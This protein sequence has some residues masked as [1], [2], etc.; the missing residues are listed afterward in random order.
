[1][2]KFLFY[3][4]G[5]RCVFKAGKKVHRESE[6]K[7]KKIKSYKGFVFRLRLTEEQESLCRQ[8]IGTCRFVWNKALE[9]KKN[10]WEH[11]KQN[12]SRAELDKR[13]TK[14]KRQ[15]TWMSL[16]PS[17]SLQQVIKDLDQAFKSF[18]NGF[19]YPLFKKKSDDKSF[20]I[21][22]GQSI[23]GQLSKKVGI[24]KLP[25]LGE[26][27]YTK[28]REVEGEI[29]HSTVYTKAGHWYI[30][31]CCVVEIEEKEQKTSK[32]GLDRGV[33]KTIQCSDGESLERLMPS[34]KDAIKLKKLQRKLAKKKKGSSNSKKLIRLIQK[35]YI[36][37]ANTRKDA[38]HKFTTKL[39][40]SH[41]LVVLEK[42]LIKN[43]TK[44]A[45]GTRASP[46]K[47]VKAK[48][49]LNRVV[50]EQCWGIIEAI[51]AYKMIWNGGAL[52][53]VDAK[54]TSQQCSKCKHVAK[55]NRKTQA[56]FKCVKCGHAENADLN[57]SKN[58]LNRYLEAEG[59]AVLV[60]GVEALASTK[61]QE[62]VMRKPVTV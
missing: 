31:F 12:I 15:A 28:S 14:W 52:A 44:S 45:K 11:N 42:L 43:M 16:A 5:R 54:Y 40:K 61:K 39:A 22:Q 25:K 30:A 51:L 33:K 47:N 59:Q 18:F 32:V 56:I 57:A 17:Q 41:G 26:V 62:L 53:Y 19:G 13:L 27:R 1:M 34:K 6:E 36:K 2:D 8:T 49:G 24:V 7:P 4:D 55:E 46:G 29:K 9:L 58:I 35:I 38:I 20:R 37:F 10:L 60:C 23:E 3:I 50:L 48:S 21:T